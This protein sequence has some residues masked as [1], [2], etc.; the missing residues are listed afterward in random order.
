MTR[1]EMKV[2]EPLNLYPVHP[3]GSL[4]RFDE[5]YFFSCKVEDFL[6]VETVKDELKD[7]KKSIIYTSTIASCTNRA[8]PE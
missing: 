3:L 4:F 5:K 7:L 8:T 6:L 2:D 1:N